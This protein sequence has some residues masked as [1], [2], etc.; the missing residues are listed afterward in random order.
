MEAF[1]AG[2]SMRAWHDIFTKD[3]VDE[4]YETVERV[5]HVK[6]LPQQMR[7]LREEADVGDIVLCNVLGQVVEILRQ[8]LA[9][10][11]RE[12]LE[13]T[14]QQQAS[15]SK[16]HPVWDPQR[17]LWL[18]GK[19]SAVVDH[20]ICLI[21]RDTV[22]GHVDGALSRKYLVIFEEKR[23][24]YVD[25]STWLHHVE[26]GQQFV[27][28]PNVAAHIQ[29]LGLQMERFDCRYLVLTD[30]KDSVGL[31]LNGDVF[32]R[33]PNGLVSH[34]RISPYP[35]KGDHADVVEGRARSGLRHVACMMAIHAMAEFR[36]LDP[37]K[38]KIQGAYLPTQPGV[39]HHHPEIDKMVRRG[40]L[41]PTRRH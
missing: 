39:Y 9:P 40:P 8:L 11:Y 32:Q 35:V 26:D 33:K 18:D 19:S 28:K 4:Y 5:T 17:N 7:L 13:I 38:S 15:R 23:L 41:N 14:I 16:E 20:A 12:E 1:S 25:S 36:L 24:G 31:Y 27:Q 30:Y 2:F 3:F 6:A 29:Q 37:H 22:T 34:V 21:R 10:H